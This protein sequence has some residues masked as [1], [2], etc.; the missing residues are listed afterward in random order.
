MIYLEAGVGIEPA[1]TALQA[2]AWPLCHPAVS[3]ALVVSFL[4]T[5]AKSEAR[6]PLFNYR[7]DAWTVKKQSRFDTACGELP[8]SPL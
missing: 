6:W 5:V 1:S 3:F 2:A 8:T 7:T 4:L